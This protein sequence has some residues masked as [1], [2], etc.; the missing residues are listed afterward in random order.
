[1]I[2]VIFPQ[3]SL[4]L[5]SPHTISKLLGIEMFIFETEYLSVLTTSKQFFNFVLMFLFFRFF[6]Y[7]T[8]KLERTH[9][10]LHVCAKI[11]NFRHQTPHIIAR[12]LRQT[13]SLQHLIISPYN[14]PGMRQSRLHYFTIWSV[15]NLNRNIEGWTVRA[16]GNYGH[17]SIQLIN[18][19][20][21]FIILSAKIV[22]LR[23]GLC[24]KTPQN[25]FP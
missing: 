20:A 4:G 10:V 21:K 3:T 7:F 18:K 2:L 14:S 9:S 24:H 22:I 11:V 17:I 16:A 25:Q 8:Q 6:P 15:A 5:I 1:M 13:N 12:Q 23:G 19:R